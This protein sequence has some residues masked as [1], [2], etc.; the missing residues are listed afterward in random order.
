VE[1]TEA[2]DIVCGLALEA[3]RPEE[4]DQQCSHRGVIVH[5]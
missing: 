1:A 4:V 2:P 5:Y 3:R